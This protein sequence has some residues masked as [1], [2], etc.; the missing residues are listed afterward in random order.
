LDL[1]EA[2][3]EGLDSVTHLLEASDMKLELALEPALWVHADGEA[4]TR[5]VVNL[6][7]NAIKYGPAGQ[8]LRVG[9]SQT[10]G[11]AKLSVADEGPGVPAPDRDRIW[12]PYRRLDRDLQTQVQGS[13]IGL[14][15]VSELVA[16]NGGRVWVDEADG[17]GARFVVEFPLLEESVRAVESAG[18]RE[19]AS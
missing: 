16:L 17:G 7:D 13:G 5:I 15:V 14:S 3:S 18:T 2:I 6:L 4:L 9:V 19:E 10:D 8:T 12:K 11:V 1:A